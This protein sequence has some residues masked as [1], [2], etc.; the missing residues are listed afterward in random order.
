VKAWRQQ[1]G[2]NVFVLESSLSSSLW[3]EI[4]SEWKSPQKFQS[5]IQSHRENISNIK[6]KS[7]QQTHTQK[8]NT[9][10]N[11]RSNLTTT[12]KPRNISVGKVFDKESTFNIWLF[13]ESI[14]SGDTSSQSSNITINYQQQFP[15][16][17]KFWCLFE[18]RQR[19]ERKQRKRLIREEKT[20]QY[21][22]RYTLWEDFFCKRFKSAR[23]IYS[24]PT[25]IYEKSKFR[26][27]W[28]QK[29]KTFFKKGE[30]F[31]I[32]WLHVPFSE[33]EGSRA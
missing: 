18:E 9:T 7:K 2:V 28:I 11:L 8:N 5:S 16:Q 20:T 30:Q 13:V 33:T 17:P 32:L 31:S 15:K 25:R 24:I 22:C 10:D 29:Q 3:L 14:S 4:V 19:K 12:K 21:G 6:S 26:H 27:K 1:R 23:N